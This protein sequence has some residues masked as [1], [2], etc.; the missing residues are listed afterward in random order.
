M[1]VG[2]SVACKI[3]PETAYGAALRTFGSRGMGRVPI[4]I[5]GR[6]IALHRSDV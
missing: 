6:R 3:E 1:I 2:S 5:P 4:G